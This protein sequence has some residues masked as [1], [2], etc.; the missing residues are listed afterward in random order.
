MIKTIIFIMLNKYNLTK[1]PTKM[2]ASTYLRKRKNP[3]PSN[4]N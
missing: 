2:S 1:Y 4:W 3:R